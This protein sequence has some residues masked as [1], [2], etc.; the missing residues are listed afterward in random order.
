MARTLSE[1]TI[2]KSVV[3]TSLGTA[4]TSGWK[5]HQPNAITKLAADFKFERR[6]PIGAGRMQ[7]KGDIVGLE[8][9]F[10]FASDV[11]KETIDAFAEGMMMALSKGSGGT[12]VAQWQI[13]ST[14]AT[15]YVVASDGALQANTLVYAR[16]LPTA[17]DNGLKVLAAGSDADEI[18]PT[19]GLSV[20][21]AP[22]SK[23]LVEIAGFRASANG[24]I[25]LDVSGDIISAVDDL[26]TLGLYV[27]QWIWIGG[28]IGGDN[29]FATAAYRGFAQVK[30]IASGKIS[31]RRR[32]WTVAAADN[33]AGKKIDLYFGRWTRNTTSQ[34]ADYIERSYTFEMTYQ[35]LGG[36]TTPEYGYNHGCYLASTVLNL[37]PGTRATM[38]LNFIGTGATDPSTTR[39]TGASS[40]PAPLS[41]ALLNCAT[42]MTRLRM[43]NADETGLTTDIKSL[44]LTIDNMVTGEEMLANLG[45][46][47]I[48][49]GDFRVTIDAVMLF[50]DDDMIAGV[51]DNRDVMLEIGIRNGD[52]GIL[53]DVPSATLEAA[54]PDI[55][56]N[57]SVKIK[58]TISANEDLTYGYAFG[59]SHFPYLPAA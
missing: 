24:S 3:E 16:G 20:D 30:L 21:A 58:S 38:E 17:A 26:S 36:P 52:G 18:K 51:R 14:S 54:T 56:P 27:G 35:T 10:A 55:T 31:L 25:Q 40:S 57:E 22:P 8:A 12:G 7:Q 15:S 48:N 41:T 53:F 11:N 1:A 50:T 47:Y 42:G 28:T 19:G 43:T 9:G 59:M 6:D 32:Q 44:K 34:S 5:Q 49:V 29:A 33:A 37:N 4:A 23:A 46:K 13:L 45:P 2:L 39:L